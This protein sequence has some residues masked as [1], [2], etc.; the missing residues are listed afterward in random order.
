[1][2]VSPLGKPRYDAIDI[3]YD[4]YDIA[5]QLGIEWG[6]KVWGIDKPHFMYR[7]GLTIED[8][9]KG[10]RLVPLGSPPPTEHLQARLKLAEDS[11]DRASPRRKLL[12]TRFIQRATAFLRG[13]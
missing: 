7:Q 9:R 5:S 2:P 12:L 10:K 4:I 6:W 3:Y 11:L 13:V 8:F 1:V